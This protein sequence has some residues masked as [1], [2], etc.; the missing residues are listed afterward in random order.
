MDRQAGCA[1]DG[2]DGFDKGLN[3]RG[4]VAVFDRGLLCRAWS[5]RFGSCLVGEDFVMLGWRGLG[6]AYWSARSGFCVLVG[7]GHK[8]GFF[9][10]FLI[11]VF[12]GQWAMVT[13][14]ACWW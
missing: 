1:G 12:G 3:R 4:W 9:F 8:V 6:S 2:S 13:W 11:R 5:A 10:F 14:W 7:V